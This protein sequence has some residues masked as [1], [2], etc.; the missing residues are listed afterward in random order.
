L[1]PLSG[2]NRD[3]VCFCHAIRESMMKT[4][5]LLHHKSSGRGY[6]RLRRKFH[7]FGKWGTPE[8]EQRYRQWLETLDLS[9]APAMKTT[10]LLLTAR[11]MEHGKRHR[12]NPFPYE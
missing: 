4:P 3:L 6:A 8:A 1:T 11:F 9:S 2:V 7:W 5:Q 10:L 12:N